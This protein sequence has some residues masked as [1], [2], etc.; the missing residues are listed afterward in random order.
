[1]LWLRHYP[2][3]NEAYR[4]IKARLEAGEPIGGQ[5]EAQQEEADKDEPDL[6]GTESSVD[7]QNPGGD[8][9]DLANVAS[10]AAANEGALP[11]EEPLTAKPQT[12]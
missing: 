5:Q 3:N 8:A 12:E 7:S 2:K 6:G 4:S 10:E 9:S 11:A 1:M